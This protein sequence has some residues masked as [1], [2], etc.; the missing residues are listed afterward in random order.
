MHVKHPLGA[1]A[2][3]QVVDI[4]RDDQQPARPFAVEPRQ[5]PMRRIG[6]DRAQRL[7]PRIVESVD[8]RGIAGKCLR[9]ADILDAMPFPEAVG[10]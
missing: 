6:L 1:R 10:A 3:V 2:P 5:R 8:G 9:R 7:A 4:L